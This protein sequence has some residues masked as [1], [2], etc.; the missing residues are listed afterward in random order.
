MLLQQVSGA[1][2]SVNLLLFD[3]FSVLII[4]DGYEL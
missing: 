3:L 2:A 1:T 4:I